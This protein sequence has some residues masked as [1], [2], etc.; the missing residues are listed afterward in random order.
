LRRKDRGK[1]KRKSENRKKN[2]TL[3]GNNKV[4]TKQTSVPRIRKA[5]TDLQKKPTR[6]IS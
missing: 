1:R 3:S 2:S 6:N 4:T 5:T